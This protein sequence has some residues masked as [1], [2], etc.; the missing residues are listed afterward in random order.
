MNHPTAPEEGDPHAELATAPDPDAIAAERRALDVD[1]ARK[2]S[3]AA[4]EI[5]QVRRRWAVEID[6]LQ[7][8]RV[9]LLADEAQARTRRAELHDSIRRRPV[10]R[11]IVREVAT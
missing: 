11:R 10:A 7:T 1:L 9:K 8:R 3:Q 5:D 4:I 6:A 2:V